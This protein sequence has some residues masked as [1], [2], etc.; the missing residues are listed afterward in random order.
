[1]PFL[2]LS[3]DVA[4]YDQHEQEQMNLCL[5]MVQSDVE[6]SVWIYMEAGSSGRTPSRRPDTLRYA[7][8]GTKSRTIMV[9]KTK[10]PPSERTGR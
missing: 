2:Y 10:N 9:K 8:N 3:V 7:C 4:S 1:M 6:T 5:C